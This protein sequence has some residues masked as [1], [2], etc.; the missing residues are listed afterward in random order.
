MIVVDIEVYKDF[1]LLATKNLK[2]GNIRVWCAEDSGSLTSSQILQINKLFRENITVSF[3]GLRYDIPLLTLALRGEPPAKIKKVSDEIIKSKQTFS[4]FRKYRLA[5]PAAWDH[6]DLFEVAPGKA[7]LKIYGGRLNAK[8]LWS[9][10]IDPDSETTKADRVTLRKYCENDLVLTELLYN[11]LEKQIKLRVAMSKQ[12]DLDLRSLSDAQI[13]ERLIVSELE[14]MGDNDVQ[15]QRDVD[16]CEEFHYQNPKIIS[17]KT[18]TLNALYERILTTPF[19]IGSSGSVVMPEWLRDEKVTIG[20]GEYKLGLGGL[21]SCEKSQYIKSDKNHVLVDYDVASYYPSIIM[22]QKLAPMALGEDFLT[23]YQ[24]LIERRIEAKRTGDTVTSNTLKIVLNGS[25]GKLGSKYSKLYAPEL[26]IQTTITGQLALLMLIESLELAGIRVVSAN[27]DGIVL[28]HD[29]AKSR[30]VDVITFN[31]EL[32]TSFELE[33]TEY[34]LLASRDVNNYCAVKLDGSVKG[35]GV[36]AP[37]SLMKNPDGQIIYKAVARFLSDGT[38]LEQTV[39]DSQDIGEFLTVR[40]VQGGAKWCEELL[41]NSIRFYK[42]ADV[43]TQ[44]HILYATNSNRVPNSSGCRPLLDLPD[45]M[46]KDVDREYYYLKARELLK[47]VGY[48]A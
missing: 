24:S 34:K 39:N 16:D 19:Q 42:S 31:W 7:S 45:T 29:R 11:S 13:A 18:D 46:P 41:G 35:K 43:S 30:T 5:V 9:L 26:L 8:R 22:Q 17:F 48:Y 14:N 23:L 6:V 3:N 47:E 40:R 27:T 36:F 1:F 10:P 28:Y 25:Y 20:L 32:D 21:H 4:V 38:P 33:R 37:P 12:Y 2:T 44:E 15:S